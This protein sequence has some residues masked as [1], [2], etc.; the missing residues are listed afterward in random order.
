MTKLIRLTCT[1]VT[2]ICT[3]RYLKYCVPVQVLNHQYLLSIK[4]VL[5]RDDLVM[6]PFVALAHEPHEFPFFLKNTPFPSLHLVKCSP[7]LSARVSLIAARCNIYASSAVATDN[8][9]EK[10]SLRCFRGRVIF[11]SVKHQH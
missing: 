4:F 1:I 6:C 8:V 3:Y 11:G 2:S 7:N 5:Y 10:Q 9:A